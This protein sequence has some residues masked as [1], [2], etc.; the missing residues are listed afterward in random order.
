MF[1]IYGGNFQSG[2]ASLLDGA[3]LAAYEDVVFVSANYRTNRKSHS[4][5]R[6]G[7]TILSAVFG[8]PPAGLV[9]SGQNLGFLDQKLALDWVQ[10]NIHAFGGDP[11]KVFVFGQ[12]AGAWSVDNLLTAMPRD[13]PFRAAAT[14]SGQYTFLTPGLI[15]TTKYYFPPLLEATNCSS[16]TGTI[17]SAVLQCLKKVPAVELKTI[18][19]QES[20]LFYPQADNRTMVAH[21]IQARLSGKFAKVPLMTGSVENEGSVNLFGSNNL[22]EFLQQDFGEVPGL[23]DEIS[24]AYPRQPGESDNEMISEIFTDWFFK[25]VSLPVLSM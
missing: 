4:S 25:C 9:A 10:R 22:T 1:F 2:S 7:L 21:P 12:S 23:V 11:K 17:D 5:V 19:E 18:I 24:A 20:L 13:P 14:I 3:A 8:F 6:S 15:D 16:K